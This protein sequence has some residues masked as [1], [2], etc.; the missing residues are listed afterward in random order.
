[1]NLW[2]LEQHLPFQVLLSSCGAPAKQAR[3]TAIW[4]GL[5]YYTIIEHYFYLADLQN[6][7]GIRV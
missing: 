2:N 6:L 7:C 1:M 4:F 3:S 5:Y